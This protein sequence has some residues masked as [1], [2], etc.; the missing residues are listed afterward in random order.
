MVRFGWGRSRGFC[1][2]SYVSRIFRA[3]CVLPTEPPG[4]GFGSRVYCVDYF[5]CKLHKASWRCACFG[6]SVVKLEESDLRVISFTGF[7]TP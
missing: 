7:R 5:S 4:A 3:I 6:F 2:H 1:S